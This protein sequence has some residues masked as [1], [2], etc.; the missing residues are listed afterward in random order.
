ME[1][2]D[3]MGTITKGMES[4]YAIPFARAKIG[5]FFQEVP[6]LGNPYKEDV[7]LQSYLRRVVPQNVS[8]HN[9]AKR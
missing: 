8:L 2:L 3:N 4:V 5:T 7:Y 9:F 1:K 6:V